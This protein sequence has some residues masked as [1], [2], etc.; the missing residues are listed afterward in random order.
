MRKLPYNL[1]DRIDNII[2]IGV[3][4]VAPFFNYFNLTPNFITTLGNICTICFF[5]LFLKK[6]FLLA[7][8]FFALSYFFDSL[9]G[10]Y[11]RKYNM[12]TKFGDWYDHLS[13]TIKTIL[14]LC[15]FYI[16]NFSLLLQL[17]PL[18]TMLFIL[19]T[20]HLANQ[21]IY[22]NDFSSSESLQPLKQLTLASKNNVED[23]L[24]Y[25]RSVGCGTVTL[26]LVLIIA[27]YKGK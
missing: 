23:Y 27:F 7:S 26:I 21:E 20:F 6:Q 12:V 8:F 13:D 18:L 3:E 9:D 5:I 16:I 25:S 2:Y 4:Y 22:Y 14:M 1:E 15:A 17:L 11:A 19:L 24:K 10:Y